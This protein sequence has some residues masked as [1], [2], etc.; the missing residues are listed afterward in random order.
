MDSAKPLIIAVMYVKMAHIVFNMGH[1]WCQQAASG[2]PNLCLLCLSHLIWL[3]LLSFHWWGR[4]W[5]HWMAENKDIFV[6]WMSFSLCMYRYSFPRVC[7]P[8]VHP[9]CSVSTLVIWVVLSWVYQRLEQQL[10]GQKVL[11]Q[12]GKAGAG[13]FHETPAEPS[14]ILCTEVATGEEPQGFWGAR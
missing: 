10:C 12:K 9:S 8:K 1:T 2:G 7:L 6:S 13:G 5:Y 14:T 11:Q 3:V 4:T